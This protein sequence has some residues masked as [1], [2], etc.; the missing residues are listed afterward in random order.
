MLQLHHDIVNAMTFTHS[1]GGP[2][3]TGRRVFQEIISIAHT[4]VNAYTKT[5]GPE[6]GLDI[7]WEDIYT[8]FQAYLSHYFRNLYRIIQFRQQKRFGRPEP[9]LYRS[10]SC[11]TFAGRTPSPVL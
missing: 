1:T 4:S 3:A 6:E 2:A 10:C 9:F 5:A 8:A 11:S 7:G